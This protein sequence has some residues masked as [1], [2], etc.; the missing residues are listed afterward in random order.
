MQSRGLYGEYVMLCRI[1]QHMIYL[2]DKFL[3]IISDTE[4]TMDFYDINI[5]VDSIDGL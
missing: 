2:H 4:C 3:T 1:I 5:D